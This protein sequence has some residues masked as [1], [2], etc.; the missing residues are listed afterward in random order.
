MS[1]GLPWFVASVLG[2]VA[3]VGLAALFLGPL[4]SEAAPYGS[5]AAG[6][7][8]I[9]A[10]I[11]VPLVI[12]SAISLVGARNHRVI[13]LLGTWLLICAS[14]VLFIYGR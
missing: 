7:G 2:A 5:P 11:L 3:F 10:A 13:A 9:A 4:K 14:A 1:R 12:S 8:G 6:I